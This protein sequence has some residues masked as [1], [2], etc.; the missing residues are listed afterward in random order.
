ML[1]DVVAAVHVAFVAW[2]LYAPFSKNPDVRAAYIVFTPFLWLHWV[3][4]DSTCALTLL[5]TKLRGLDTVSES[6]VHRIVAPVY[7]ISDASIRTASWVITV[8]LWVYALKR[9]TLGEI[10]DALLG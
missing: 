9:T 7:Q 5:E 1:A 4:N 3:L 2:M 6:F 8:V 10:R